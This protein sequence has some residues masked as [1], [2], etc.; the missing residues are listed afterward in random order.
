MT[1]TQVSATTIADSTRSA[2]FV[3]LEHVSVQ[4]GPGNDN[5]T[6]Y[7]PWDYTR[8]PNQTQDWIIERMGKTS[9][10]RAGN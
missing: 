5:L 6:V 8:L 2:S 9:T 3:N 1:E 10:A 7:E 4:G